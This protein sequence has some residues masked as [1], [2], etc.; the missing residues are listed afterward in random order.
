MVEHAYDVTEIEVLEFDASVRKRTG[1]YFGVGPGSPKL[2]TNILCA[3]AGHALHPATSVAPEHSLRA[4]V[5][6]T[7]RSSFT[8]TMDQPHDWESSERPVLGYFGSLLGPEWWLLAAAAALSSRVT[9]EMWCA[10]RGF[11]QDLAGI[12]PVTGLQE[13]GPPEGSGTAVRLDLDPGHVGPHF[14]LPV[15][16]E[17]L[18]PHGPHCS[19]P[20]GRGHVRLRD[21]RRGRPPRDV[22][23]R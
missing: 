4:L 17:S 18:D 6:I 3:V 7:G 16:L 2:P 9:V 14:A 5:E 8:I 23:H 19:A 20:A 10:G 11:R 15:D 21:H 13:F 1:L 12:R 22:L